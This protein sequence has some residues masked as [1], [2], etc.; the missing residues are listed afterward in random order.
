M[1][2]PRAALSELNEKINSLIIYVTY[3]IYFMQNIIYIYIY[4]LLFILNQLFYLYF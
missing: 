2:Y 1:P 3:E 4:N